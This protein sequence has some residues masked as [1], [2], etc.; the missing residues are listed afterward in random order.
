MFLIYFPFCFDEIEHQMTLQE[1]QNLNAF[2]WV[3]IDQV[4]FLNI[5]YKKS[6]LILFLMVDLS[7]K[8]TILLISI[9]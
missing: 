8:S 4:S 7:G 9:K 6:N 2:F 1:L 3:R 5:Y